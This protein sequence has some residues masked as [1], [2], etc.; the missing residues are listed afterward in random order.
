MPG[1]RRRTV[2]REMTP[3]CV[4]CERHCAYSAAHTSSLSKIWTSSSK[5][6]PCTRWT[7]DGSRTQHTSEGVGDHTHVSGCIRTVMA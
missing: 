4:S 1:L 5:V 3:D 6:E 7:C 2:H